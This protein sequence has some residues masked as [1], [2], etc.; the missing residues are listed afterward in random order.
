M[1]QQLTRF[2]HTINQ[3]NKNEL[4]VFG[5]AV[6]KEQEK[7]ITTN[8]TFIIRMDTL[9]IVDVNSKGMVPFQRAA[10]A[11][12]KINTNEVIM[13]GGA[14]VDRKMSENKLYHLKVSNYV[15]NWS[16]VKT[17]GQRPSSRYGHTLTFQKPYLILFGGSTG[18]QTLN[19]TWC[20][21]LTQEK[22]Q[23][24][25]LQIKGSKPSPRVYHSADLCKY[26]A[27]SGMIII[28][29]GRDN[30]SQTNKEI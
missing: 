6:E 15:G 12:T 18:N 19:D 3:I 4:L 26:G 9:Q 22:M 20:I 23:W 30:E 25:F 10:H 14:H 7:F 13:F 29:G 28:F 5:G 2:G 11:T 16:E 8:D 24:E 21:D 17:N 1:Q 27:A